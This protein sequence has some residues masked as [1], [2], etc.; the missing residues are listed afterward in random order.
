[1]C[2]FEYKLMFVFILMCSFVFLWCKITHRYI[3]ICIH[4]NSAVDTEEKTNLNHEDES[5]SSSSSLSPQA[6]TGR[7]WTADTARETAWSWRRTLTA[8]LSAAALWSTPT[9]LPAPTTWSRSNSK[10]VSGG[11]LPRRLWFGPRPFLPSPQVVL[12]GAC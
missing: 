7:A 8:G 6:A 1:M 10:W 4:M 5:S 2:M 12:R 11:S 9:S 3:S